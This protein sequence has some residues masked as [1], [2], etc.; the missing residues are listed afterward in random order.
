VPKTATKR[1]WQGGTSVLLCLFLVT[2]GLVAQEQPFRINV[3]VALVTVDAIVQDQVGRPV[4]NLEKS[5]FEVFEDGEPQDIAYFATS[6]TPRSMLLLFDVS[7][8]TGPQRPFMVQAFNVFL[9]LM[10][11]FD[12][13]ALASFAGGLRMLMPWRNIEGKPKD[14]TVPAPQNL[15]YVYSAIED[16][17]ASFKNEKGRRGMIV[18][19]D[20]RDTTF[21]NDVIGSHKVRE[22]DAD[23]S[24][25]KLVQNVR[26]YGIPL[27]VIAINSDRNPF[28]STSDVEY[29]GVKNAIGEAGARKY[30]TEVRV[31]MEQLA[32]STN[33]RILYPRNLEEVAPLYDAIGRELGRS[34]SIG[35]APANPSNDGRVR[36]IEVRVRRDSVH[37]SQSRDSYT[38]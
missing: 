16:G 3:N 32:S 1:K 5:D 14:V 34:Y 27:Y 28:E 31:R 11:P 25:Q 24:F 21:F 12:R 20:G 30:L 29:T 37:V 13:V 35:Y 33:G 2:T 10:R 26:K 23:K 15:S 38:R 17:L 4:T 9:A 6:E 8:S 36:K 18:M 22:A 7:G 19:T